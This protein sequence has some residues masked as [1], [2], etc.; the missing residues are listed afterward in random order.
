VILRLDTFS[1]QKLPKMAIV[2]KLKRFLQERRERIER[3]IE[4]IVQEALVETVNE[5]QIIVDFGCGYGSYTIPAAKMVGEKGKVYALDKNKKALDTVMKK[6]EA[7]GLK[8]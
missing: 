4:A 3:S 6:A 1:P 2:Q 5:G 8:I 7:Q